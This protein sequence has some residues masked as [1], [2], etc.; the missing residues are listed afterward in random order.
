[1][2]GQ[3]KRLEL[4]KWRYVRCCL[5]CVR[6]LITGLNV[7]CSCRLALHMRVPHFAGRKYSDEAVILKSVVFLY[8]AHGINGLGREE[9]AWK[10]SVEFCV[11]MV[12]TNWKVDAF[13]VLVNDIYVLY[14]FA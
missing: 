7:R 13:C 2:E 6:D 11:R 4:K 14:A 5:M 12:V 10:A 8:S 1:M 3:D 9:N